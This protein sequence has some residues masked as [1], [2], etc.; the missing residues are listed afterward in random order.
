MHKSVQ[1]NT[2]IDVDGID[3]EINPNVFSSNLSKTSIYFANNISIDNNSEVIE[4]GVGTGFLLLS[5]NNKY[6]NLKLFGTDNNPHAVSLCKRNMAK[7]NVTATIWKSNLFQDI[8]KTKFDY[9]IFNPPLLRVNFNGKLSHLEKS[10]FDNTD[11]T[12]NFLLQVSGF[13]HS[14]TYG[15]ILAT[16][17]QNIR[18]SKRSEFTEYW[19][20]KYNFLYKALSYYDVNY[21]IYSVYKFWK[22]NERSKI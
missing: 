5:L 4:I 2:I 12:N 10:I 13:M 3:I 18:N 15:F 1:K 22:Y 19:L 16:N 20:N 21:E 6:H 9:I 14:G 17:R 8:P 11:T 7:H